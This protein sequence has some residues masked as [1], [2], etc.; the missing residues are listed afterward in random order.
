MSNF[1][2]IIPIDRHG[3]FCTGRQ[4]LEASIADAVFP[5]DPSQDQSWTHCHTPRSNHTMDNIANHESNGNKSSVMITPEKATENSSK[6]KTQA[7]KAETKSW[8]RAVLE[9][10]PELVTQKGLLFAL[11]HK[12][13]LAIIRFML[14][15]NPNVMNF[16]KKGPTPLQEAVRHN[17]ELGVVK[18]L[19]DASPVGECIRN[20]DFPES[21]LEYVKRHCSNRTDLI[22]LLSRKNKIR[23]EK[24][25]QQ[26]KGKA[27]FL[28]HFN[29][30]LSLQQATKQQTPLFSPPPA[31]SARRSRSRSIVS[32]YSASETS[33][34]PKKDVFAEVKVSSNNNNSQRQTTKQQT[35]L[36][37]PPPFS[38]HRSRSSSI[39]SP[40]C[41]S[42]P[43]SQLQT[44]VLA[45]VKVLSNNDNSL[46]SRSTSRSPAIV[47]DKTKLPYTTNKNKIDREEMNNMKTLC[48]HLWKSQRKMAK[49]MNGC[50]N[51]IESQSKLLATMGTKEDILEELMKAQRSQMF[52]NL[53]ALDIKERAYQTKMDKMEER[54]VQQLEKRLHSWT[55]SMRLWNESTREQLQELRA[56]VDSEAEINDDFRNNMTDWI[57]KYQQDQENNP[58]PPSHVF[59]TNMGEVNE[60][61]PL[62]AAFR[63]A[64]CGYSTDVTDGDTDTDPI[65]GVDENASQLKRVKKRPWKPLF[66]NRDRIPL[67]D[68]Q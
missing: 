62:C 34:Q 38:A 20:A 13:P 43:P 4:A 37:S 23:D 52:R 16:P 47:P 8:V 60:R 18:M 64:F 10:E 51:G 56:F 42:E 54:Y 65:I 11:R 36:L 33:S 1:S 53:I 17:A 25:Q 28:S 5:L 50:K 14:T 30:N 41:A 46:Q 26:Q 68:D 32:L 67:S 19:L 55:G 45:E 49:Q 2:H 63:G 15:I 39:I 27:G 6:H 66:K 48:V 35:P 61:V 21:P 40:F 44:N 7:A 57:E 58:S 22:E 12:A 59:A 3:F 24:C 31:F 9:A 29:S